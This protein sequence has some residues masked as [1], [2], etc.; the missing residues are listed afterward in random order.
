MNRQEHWNALY[1]LKRD[2]VSWFEAVPSIS[3]EMLEAAGLARNTSVID[4]GAG[5]SRLIDVLLARGLRRLT[6][7]DVS[8]EA[9]EHIRTRVGLLGRT[10]T[11]I[12]SNVTGTWTTTPMDIW[13]DRA[14]FHFL[15][16][17]HDRA[18]YV[19]RLNDSVKPNGSAILAT[20]APDGPEIC[21]G[22]PVAR[23]SPEALA[24]ELGR[25]FALVQSRR[26]IHITP[27]GV[28][29]SFQYS[30]FRKLG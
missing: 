14:V 26:H 5:E 25:E 27:R 20:F 12:E 16:D 13:H 10:V 18:S 30:R 21:S 1:R 7:L 6:A 19:Q 17:R 23:Y 8:S 28:T 3:L 2:E 9:L 15:T 22:L 29:Q 11:W 4:I 24:R